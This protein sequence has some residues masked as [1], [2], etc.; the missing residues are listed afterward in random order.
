MRD[1]AVG[2]RVCEYTG[3]V[4]ARV[5]EY[6]RNVKKGVHFDFS[7]NLCYLQVQQDPAIFL[8]FRREGSL[9]A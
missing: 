7:T 1:L 9:F 5:V 3:R 4:R 8:F 2:M 6:T